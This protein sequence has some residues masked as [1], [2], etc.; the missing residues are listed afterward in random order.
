LFGAWSI[1]GRQHKAPGRLALSSRVEVGTHPLTGGA[2]AVL[3]DGR[4][5]VV[6]AMAQAWTFV[7]QAPL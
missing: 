7:L 5:P 3:I 4:R 2:R 1:G 6:Q